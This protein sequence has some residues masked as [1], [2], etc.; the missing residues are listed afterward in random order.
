MKPSLFYL[1]GYPAS[2]KT[3]ALNKAIEISL[4]EF[5]YAA[6]DRDEQGFTHLD[7]T[8]GDSQYLPPTDGCWPRPINGNRVHSKPFKH[9]H[10]PNGF[11]QIGAER[12]YFGGTDT[13]ALNI[14]PKVLEG[15]SGTSNRLYLAEGD[16]LSNIKFFTGVVGLG[17]RLQIVYIHVPKI[18]AEYR[19]YKRGHHFNERWFRG[20]LTKVDNLVNHYKD[21]GLVTLDGKQPPEQVAT[22]LKE[23][24]NG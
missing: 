20:R 14:Q 1:I 24:I 18:E 11:I 3:T 15:L 17:I 5:W 4:T 10:Y 2:G 8:M 12:K 22:A 6:G 13:L 7:S 21:K 9:T 16:R 23:I 19:A